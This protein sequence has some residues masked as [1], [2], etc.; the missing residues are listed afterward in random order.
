MAA[1]RP[2]TPDQTGTGEGTSVR[3]A[4]LQEAGLYFLCV[5]GAGEFPAGLP[6]APAAGGPAHRV[7]VVSPSRRAD[8]R[9]DLFGPDGSP[10]E[11][12]G[13]GLRAAAKF[14]YE[15]GRA[16]KTQLSFETHRGLTFVELNVN[17]G[18][19]DRARIDMG[20][21]VLEA[22]R[23]PTYLPGNP[24]VEIPMTWPDTMH[25]VTC[26]GVGDPHAVVFVHEL[27]DDLVRGVGPLLE[28]HALFPLHT[29]VEFVKAKGRSEVAARVW[30]RGGGERPSA[31][32]AAC[33]VVVAGVL[34]GRTDRR[35][36]VHMPGGDLEVI[37][38]RNADD[39][40]YL[41]GPVAEAP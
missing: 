38:D 17:N 10:M 12:C 22:A 9:V 20:A 16:P 3:S 4:K 28:T 13:D 27:S 8:A 37:W 30:G 21:P 14:V 39:H 40:L 26:V 18:K 29:N 2:G 15:H 23:I 33:A 11:G 24:P 7:V 19:V 6:L 5:E 1:K 32:S 25:N 35:L 36:T 34:T 31:A 41:T